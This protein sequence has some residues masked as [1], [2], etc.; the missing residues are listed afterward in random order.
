MDIPFSP[1]DLHSISFCAH[2]PFHCYFSSNRLSKLMSHP[3]THIYMYIHVYIYICGRETN[4]FG[5]GGR[6]KKNK[7][8]PGGAY[9]PGPQGPGLEG[10]RRA[11][12]GLDP[13]GTNVLRRW[14]SGAC[15]PCPAP[16]NHDF[17]SLDGWGACP[18]L[19]CDTKP[20]LCVANR[21]SGPEHIIYCWISTPALRQKRRIGQTSTAHYN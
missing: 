9:G 12:Q 21:S 16:Q 14:R 20:R 5:S 13:S 15:P 19:S 2:P 17:A 18:L 10:P 11:H 6:V 4:C 8:G 1:L 3:H 7:I